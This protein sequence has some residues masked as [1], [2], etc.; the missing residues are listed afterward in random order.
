MLRDKDAIA[1]IA[2][3]DTNAAKKF[4]E[5]TLGLKPAPTRERGVLSYKTGNSAILV[6]E[7]RYAGTNKATA[8]TWVVDDVEGVV[9]DLK[10]KGVA[11]E[12]YDLP[13]TKRRGDVHVS[14]KTKVAWFKD[15]DGNILSLVNG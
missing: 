9:R 8:A 10:G 12:H 3:K 7:S 5:D 14:G 6:Y 4:Y 13:D 11:F 2:V 1:T 15:P